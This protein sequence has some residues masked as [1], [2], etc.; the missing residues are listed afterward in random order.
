M[1]VSRRRVS[2][3]IVAATLAAILAASPAAA[4]TSGPGNDYI[5]QIGRAGVQMAD[6]VPA[7][8]S[9]SGLVDIPSMPSAGQGGMAAENRP[10]MAEETGWTLVWIL[11]GLLGLFGLGGWAA[12]RK[13]KSSRRR[14]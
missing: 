9:P 1:R 3:A 5:V 10:V 11:A 14:F 6:D 13:R 4:Q 2:S 7:A 8:N 12:N